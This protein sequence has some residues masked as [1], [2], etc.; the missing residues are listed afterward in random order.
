MTDASVP[1][2]ASGPADASVPADADTTADETP[3][4]RPATPR[5]LALTIAVVFGVL[6]AYDVWE[7]V[8]NLVGLN[9]Q[10]GSLGVPLTA[11]GLTLLIAALIVPFLVFG[12][13]FWLGR[14]RAPLAQVVLFLAGYALI[15]ALAF[16]AAVFF[17]LG[18]FDLS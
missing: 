12:V 4:A 9:L 10:A 7:A 13:A 1:A 5:W 3:S 15:Q 8:G 6:Y 11:L 2:D 14:R 17:G 16:D 18:G